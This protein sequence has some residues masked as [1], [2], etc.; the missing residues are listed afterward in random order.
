M[1]HVGIVTRYFQHEAAYL[2]V[3]VADWFSCTGRDVAILATDAQPTPLGCSWDHRVAFYAPKYFTAW[4]KHA[5][6]IIWTH[7]PSPEQVSWANRN[8]IRTVIVPLWQELRSEHR[9]AFRKAS[10][11]VCPSTS[12][13]SLLT[14]RWKLTNGRTA[15]WC[16]G[17]PLTQKRGLRDATRLKVAI[18]MLDPL[19]PEECTAIVG[20]LASVLAGE[21]RLAVSVLYIPSRL[22]ASCK[23]RLSKLKKKYP[24]RFAVYPK[25]RLID[26]PLLLQQ[27]DV[28]VWL[29]CA[30]N[31][32]RLGLVS[33]ASGT[34]VITLKQPVIDEFV[35]LDN[36]IR[37]PAEQ[38][39]NQL[40]VP[41]VTPDLKYLEQ[42]LVGLAEPA[43]RT[44]VSQLQAGTQY[45]LITR[46]AAFDSAWREIAEGL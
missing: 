38:H 40:G 26:Q 46:A 41:M 18:S 42:V 36:G 21:S 27:H 7:P 10:F 8:K 3:R 14:T 20:S 23:K 16:P 19:Y 44:I 4:A 25:P 43:G 45:G 2:A 31:S 12:S 6:A 35:T 29:T 15:P 39:E 33:L 37:L 24:E 9:K 32:G 13:M 11:V 1:A 30:E 34:P 28:L 17:V 22:P 5:S